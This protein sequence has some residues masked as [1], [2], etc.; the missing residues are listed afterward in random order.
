MVPRRGR[1]MISMSPPSRWARSS[2]LTSPRPL[3]FRR[4]ASRSKPRPSSVT[5]SRCVAGSDDRDGEPPR[6]A[7]HGA[8]SQ[9]L[10]GNSKQA[11]RDI[12]VKIGEVTLCREMHLH[13]MPLFHFD[14]V[15]AQC[16][17]ETDQ[18]KRG[19]VQF[20]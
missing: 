6:G 17:R 8:V 9:G 11:Q 14:A 2:M 16:R 18:A 5:V 3:P 13:V 20:V 12:G 10:L 15:G 7:V 1:V 19:G 4:T